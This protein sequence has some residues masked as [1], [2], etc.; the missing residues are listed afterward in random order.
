MGNVL[1]GIRFIDLS[2][3]ISG[4]YF[5]SL[6]ADMGAEVIRVERPGGDEDRRFGYLSP[7]GDSYAFV[8][9]MRNKK[10]ITLNLDHLE[11]KEIFEKLVKSSDII[12]E[13]FAMRDKEKLGLI[14]ESL[15]KL[16]FSI[17]L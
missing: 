4:P 1:K 14:F 5:S 6:L 17:I 10:A 8:N 11:G 16:K 13:N 12:L 7:T 15:R 3:H 9:R 2:R